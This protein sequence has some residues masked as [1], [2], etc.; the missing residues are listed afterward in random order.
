MRSLLK[1]RKILLGITGS[2]A[3]YKAPLLI[4]ELIK[5]GAEVKT[6]MTQSAAYFVT[7]T[8][9]SNLSRNPAAMDMFD[10]K[11]QTSGAWHIHLA[12]WCD[13]MLIAPCSATTMS[14]IAAGN[15]ENSLSTLAIAL[16]REIPLIIAPAMDSTM[17]LH[18]AVQRN[19]QQLKKDGA[20]VIP[21]AEGELSSGLEGPGRLPEIE[22]LIEYVTKIL[23]QSDMKTGSDED[24]PVEEIFEKSNDSEI[25]EAME[26]PVPSLQESIDKDEF[27]AELELEELKKNR[28]L[29]KGKKILVT[30]GP[31]RENIDDVRYISNYSSGKMG[32]ALADRAAKLGAEVTLI[33]G[34]VSIAAPDNVRR[35]DV[36]NAGEMFI[37]SEK[38]FPDADAAIMAAAVADY[39]PGEA[40]EGKIKKEDK[41]KE[42]TIKLKSTKDIL[43]SL[44][45]L[46]KGNQL[47][48]GF[49]LES[50]NE[51]DNGWKKM[52]NKNA[53]MI[54]V[55]AA[56]KPRS[57]FETDDNTIT[58]L[59]K[60]G[61]EEFFPAMSKIKCAEV[62]LKSVS[63][64]IE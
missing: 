9:L 25:K 43:A 19:V 29:L 15:C 7:P 3:A 22:E 27:N 53:D 10:D 50:E 38:F 37:E 45:K 39:T 49:A 16:P 18:P 1:N 33:A 8:V 2:I 11:T 28:M 30:A 31:T 59:T 64:M 34:P 47:L 46:K 42:L 44:G 63:E 61:R 13:L 54:V 60:N 35:I 6:V 12:H 55:N 20:K 26:R 21:P 58:I 40:A 23:A 24:E 57:G 41:G 62:I 17:W 32:F 56:N 52:K 4:R 48:V 14:R 36:K 51:V 5:E